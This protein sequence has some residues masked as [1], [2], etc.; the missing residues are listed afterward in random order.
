[1]L[2]STMTIK[3]IITVSK[4]HKSTWLKST[5]NLSS[6]SCS[7]N[8]THSQ[9]KYNAMY[10]KHKYYFKSNVSKR[11]P[12]I[13]SW[14]W[15]VES[16]FYY[17]NYNFFQ[18]SLQHPACVCLLTIFHALF[19]LTNNLTQ[20]CDQHLVLKILK[21]WIIVGWWQDL[22]YIP[23]PQRAQIEHQIFWWLVKIKRVKFHDDQVNYLN[24]TEK[25]LL[26]TFIFLISL[27]VYQFICGTRGR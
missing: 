10:H 15:L 23:R 20:S 17:Y 16:Q 24:R 8:Q 3:I 14:E 9:N 7:R 19:P 4:N 6:P 22:G 27:F 11:S 13:I 12:V 18:H 2:F 26:V 21:E 1:M 5:Y 25:K